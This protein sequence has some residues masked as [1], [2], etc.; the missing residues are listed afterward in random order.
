MAQGQVHGGAI[1][2]HLDLAAA[3]AHLVG[4]VDAHRTHRAIAD[5]ASISAPS[6]TATIQAFIVASPADSSAILGRPC[7]RVCDRLS[8][9][10]SRVSRATAMACSPMRIDLLLLDVD[11]V[12]VQYQRALACCIWRRHC[13]FVPETVQAALYDSGLEAAHDNGT[14]DGPAYLAQLGEL[15]GTTVDVLHGPRRGGPPAIRRRPCCSGCRP[16][17]CRW[18]C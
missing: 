18:P 1:S 12:L 5:G 15:L 11:G 13:R 9:G 3:E 6:P 16:C 14:L 10:C 17:G 8:H 7:G 4:A 2:G